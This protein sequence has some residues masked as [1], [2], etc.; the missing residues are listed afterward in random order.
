MFNQV[1][2]NIA[3]QKQAGLFED[4]A[5][6]FVLVAQDLKGKDVPASDPLAAYWAGSISASVDQKALKATASRP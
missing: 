4:G 6:D 3:A 2:A 5:E 1:S